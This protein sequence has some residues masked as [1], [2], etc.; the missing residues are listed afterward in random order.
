M[1]STHQQ[2]FRTPPRKPSLQWS[3]TYPSMQDLGWE[4]YFNRTAG[5]ESTPMKNNDIR[6]NSVIDS[7]DTPTQFITFHDA[8]TQK[9]I[10]R[11]MESTFQ[12]HF[13]SPPKN[14]SLL[15]DHNGHKHI[16]VCSVLVGNYTT[17]QQG[18]KVPLWK[19]SISDTIQWQIPSTYPHNS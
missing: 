9:C 6:F 4:L 10:V 5:D 18:M 15:V 1:E 11:Q 14:Y 8:H 3:Q 2:H 16:L 7:I 12:Q 17:G 13:L 19:I